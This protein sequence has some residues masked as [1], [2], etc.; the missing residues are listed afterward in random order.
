MYSK[1]GGEKYFQD[2]FKQKINQVAVQNV[3]FFDVYNYTFNT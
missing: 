2:K 3:D 1:F